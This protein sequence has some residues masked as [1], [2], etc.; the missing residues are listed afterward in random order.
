[1]GYY[2]LIG[3]GTELG[4]RVI[5]DDQCS[6]ECDVVIGERTLV[7]YR[8][9]ICSEATIGSGCVVGGFVA[10]RTTIGDR[11]RVFGK[12]VHSQHHPNSGW[13]SDESIEPSAVVGAGA[14]VGFGAKVIGRVNLGGGCYVCAG[15]IVTKDVPPG[16]IVRGV[17]ELIK[18]EKWGGTLGQSDYFRRSSEGE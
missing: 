11:A 8:A 1:M 5:V 2:S 16:F 17:N 14:F 7:I 13:D 9:Q 18:P 4:S 6:V 3:A 10:E 15:A 12:F